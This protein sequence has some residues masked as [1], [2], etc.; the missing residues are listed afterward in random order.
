MQTTYSSLADAQALV[1]SQIPPY[2]RKEILLYL[3]LFGYKPERTIL[4]VH[5]AGFFKK[6][7]SSPQEAQRRIASTKRYGGTTF[8]IVGRTH[9]PSILDKVASPRKSRD[10]ANPGYVGYLWQ[11]KDPDKKPPHEILPIDF[12]PAA[13][14]YPDDW[15]QMYG[16]KGFMIAMHVPTS[17]A[18]RKNRLNR[19]LYREGKIANPKDRWN[20]I[21]RVQEFGFAGDSSGTDVKAR[22]DVSMSRVNSAA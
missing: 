21:D 19:A 17:F 9:D 10:A 5:I 13:L 18:S 14:H 4:Q 12:M 2:R 22:H 6:G 1:S 20:F 8:V 16:T 7:S 3:N 11:G 15:K